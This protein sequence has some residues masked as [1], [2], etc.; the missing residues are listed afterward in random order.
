MAITL[1]SSAVRCEIKKYIYVIVVEWQL[2]YRSVKNKTASN[3]SNPRAYIKNDR[4][5]CDWARILDLSFHF[6]ILYITPIDSSLVNKKYGTP[7]FWLSSHMTSYSSAHTLHQSTPMICIE[8]NGSQPSKSHAD[9][10]HECIASF[11]QSSQE[12]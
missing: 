8:T 3:R 12:T 5:D 7:H 6:S 1:L 4:S 11:P 9:L 2:S 10:W